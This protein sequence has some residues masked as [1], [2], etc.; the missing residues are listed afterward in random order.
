MR[1]KL[2]LMVDLLQY[3]VA[4]AITKKNQLLHCRQTMMP[5]RPLKLMVL[6]DTGIVGS[7]QFAVLLLN[8]ISAHIMKNK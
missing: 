6:M 5:A 1:E 2:S 7:L 8:K 3:G 4:Y